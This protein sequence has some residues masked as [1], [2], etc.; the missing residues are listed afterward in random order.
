MNLKIRTLILFCL[1]VLYIL[2][3]L[4]IRESAKNP[5]VKPFSIEKR[6]P[7]PVLSKEREVKDLEQNVKKEITTSINAKYIGTF[8]ID[9]ETDET[10]TGMA[11]IDYTFSITNEFIQLETNTYHEPIQCNGTY[12]AVEKNHILELYYIGN[13]EFCDTV[14][15]MF[16][17]R[18][19]GGELYAKGLGSEGTYNNWIELKRI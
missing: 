19:E 16:F 3:F 2:I 9:V 5:E 11:S 6:K 15:P 12:K 18:E 4:L 10:M 14:N 13:D 7:I 8:S 1:G 17:L